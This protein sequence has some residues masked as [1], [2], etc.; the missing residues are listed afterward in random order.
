MAAGLYAAVP[1]GAGDTIISGSP[2]VFSK[3]VVTIAG[4]GAGNVVFYDNA[5]T[6]TGNVILAIPATI[7]APNIYPIEAA[8]HNGIVATN[9]ANGPG[10][11]VWID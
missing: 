2:T 3:V 8:V 9:V 10:L 1:T 4:T 7:A 6:H 5:T 11:I